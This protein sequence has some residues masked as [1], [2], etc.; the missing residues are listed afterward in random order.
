MP[1]TSLVDYIN[2]RLQELH[3]QSRLRTYT[4]MEFQQGH[5]T[6][7]VNGF[8]LVPYQLPVVSNIDGH[9]KII[10]RSGQ[11]QLRGRHDELLRQESIYIHALDINDVVFLDRFLRT[12]HA[13]YH[14]SQERDPEELLVVSVHM[15]HVSAISENH[16]RIFEDLLEKLG[17]SP[18]QV[19]LRL[20]ARTLQVDPHVRTAAQS[21]ISRGYRLIATVR[22]SHHEEPGHLDWDL[23][24]ARGPDWLSPA[25]PLLW[26]WRRQHAIAS[27]RN[28]A[29][30]H[31]I[32]LWLSGLD[33]PAWLDDTDLSPD[34]ILE[35]PAFQDIPSGKQVPMPSAA[36]T[37]FQPE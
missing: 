22:E 2:G 36:D 20:D 13:L 27:W 8:Q 5:L 33:S 4:G 10:G 37:A 35:G 32:G 21:F 29:R 30:E 18:R 28:T 23:L 26:R 24:S 1:L 9:K 16:G 19:V 12:F 11:F 14:L 31:G 6:A 15:R 17:L 7:R 34:D 3:P 25:P